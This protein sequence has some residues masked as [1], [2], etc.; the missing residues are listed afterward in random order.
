M[1]I[2]SRLLLALAVLVG[3]LIGVSAFDLWTSR[4]HDR[5]LAGIKHHT[6]DVTVELLPVQLLTQS[7]QVAVVEVQQVLND[8]ALTHN[9]KSFDEAKEYAA[10]FD[11]D[12][13]AARQKVE[14]SPL[15]AARS[16]FSLA[17][18]AC[19]CVRSDASC[20]YCCMIWE[21]APPPE[22]VAWAGACAAAASSE[23]I[24][25]ARTSQTGAKVAVAMLISLRLAH[26]VQRHR[27]R[28]FDRQG[29][30]AL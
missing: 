7:M 30:D 13:I 12:I 29:I 11:R 21:L 18:S 8:A 1:S 17:F 3:A 28:H 16:A 27:L 5:H 22:R 14:R 23:S 26:N 20:W 2:Q 15:A 24:A 25:M 9:P 19:S 10:Q 6:H 4:E